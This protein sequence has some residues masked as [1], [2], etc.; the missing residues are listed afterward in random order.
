MIA[1]IASRYGIERAFADQYLHRREHSLELQL[2]F[3]STVKPQAKVVPIL[4]GS[5]HQMIEEGRYPHENEAYESFAGSLTEALRDRTSR[6][7]RIAFIAGVDMAHVG[8][9][10]GDPGALSPERMRSIRSRDEEYLRSIELGDHRALFDHIAED[11]DARRI[12]GF[13]T[14]Y[15]VLDVLRR[16]GI[17]TSC[18]VVAYDQAV[19]YE[20]DCAVTFAGLAIHR[21]PANPLIV[22]DI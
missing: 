1:S 4:V 5:F 6:G 10:F 8:R 9:S 16:S 19:D 18:D 17:P 21:E 13:P 2:P 14:M 7:E 15:L 3:L 12:C 20:S 22:N 11:L